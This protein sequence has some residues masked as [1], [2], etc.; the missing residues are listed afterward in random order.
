MSSGIVEPSKQGT[1]S[2]SKEA[3][4]GSPSRGKLVQR[5]LDASANLP[6]FMKDLLITQA[7][8]VAGT[9]AAAFIVERQGD[10]F[11]LRLIHHIRPDE[12]DPETR[13]NAVRAFQNIIQ[14]CVAQR[15]DG[16][17]EVGSPDG[18]DAQFCLVTV[19][20]NEGEVVAASAVITRC[21]DMERA[22]QRLTSMQL[23]AGYFELFSLR[24]YVEQ[25]RT[26]AERHQ[27]VL[28]YS[29]A[30]AT[31][32]GFEAAAMGLCNELATRAGAAR[33]ALGW[34]KG[35]N[36]RVKALS[37][38]E[39]FD[40]KQELIV[41]LEKVMEEC[42]DQEEPVR[43]DP[44]GNSS[45]NVT[46]MAALHSQQHAGMG[47]VLSIPLR[48]RD[49]LVGV[50]TLEWPARMEIDAQAEASVAVAT[51]LL[52]PALFDRYENDRWLP[53]KAYHSV[54]NLTKLAI[55]P[56][57]MGVKLVLLTVL[58][59]VAFVVFYTPMYH[60]RSPFVIVTLDKRSVTPAYEGRL[61]SVNVK[62]GQ[63][64]RVGDVLATMET[65]E[66]E[67]QFAEAKAE[68]Q[69][70]KHEAQAYRSDR[71]GRDPQ[72]QG[73]AA[74]AESEAM[75]AFYKMTLAEHMINLGQIKAAIN[76]VVTSDPFVDKAGATVRPSDVLFEISQ[77]DEKD[78][79]RIGV[80]IELHVPDR[81]IQDVRRAYEEKRDYH[82]E[83]STVSFPA[84]EHKFRIRRIVEMGE[85][86]DGE[87]VFKVYATLT[88]TPQPWMIPGLTG[89]GRVDIEKRRFGWIW[90]HRL[91]DW[92]RLKVWGSGLI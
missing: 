91:W 7:T 11:G 67:T 85:P 76:G 26:V 90:T 35:K 65:L 72:V 23:V 61:K 47:T 34:L 9:E 58:A 3:Q 15:K 16:A 48:R 92:M 21:R 27:Q 42:H 1:E 49:E 84:L 45:Q 44:D 13:A 74:Q 19:L 70:K 40:K 20:R 62:K 10:K 30:V 59:A 29:S 51:E 28:Q 77:S 4:A 12:S 18:G 14:P 8:V 68:W 86:K 52:A 53:V 22:K 57:H 63:P 88:E 32:E 79:S 33:V 37:H 60:V 81:D 38:T 54:K 55:G 66:Y 2:S 83:I 31:A 39:K 80:E 17:I 6:A 43:F 24:R 78:P 56:R 50:L 46:R 64:V 25:A 73:K 36:I 89:E 87:N 5:L 82:G 69:S 75:V 71:S 41:S